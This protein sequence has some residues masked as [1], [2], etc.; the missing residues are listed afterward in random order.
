MRS[1]LV[2]RESPVKKQHPKPGNIAAPPSDACTPTPASHPPPSP[3]VGPETAN[4]AWLLR[5]NNSQTVAAAAS[6]SACRAHRHHRLDEFVADVIGTVAGDGGRHH[7]VR[8][9]AYGILRTANH[10]CLSYDSPLGRT[11]VGTDCGLIN[12]RQY[13]VELCVSG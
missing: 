13:M 2:N 11:S 7:S 10:P 9:D 6:A 5:I 1:T 4:W 8:L 3:P 12:T